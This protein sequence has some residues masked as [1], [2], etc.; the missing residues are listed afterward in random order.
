MRSKIYTARWALTGAVMLLPGC[1]EITQLGTAAQPSPIF[2][3]AAASSDVSMDAAEPTGSPYGAYLAGLYAG[4]QQDISSAADFMLQALASDP[5]NQQLLDR[6]FVFN[7]ADGRR[8]K[9]VE[10]ARRIGPT[11]PTQGLAGLVLAVDA[12]ARGDLDEADDFLTQLPEKG[13]NTVTAPLLRSWVQVAKGDLEAAIE[14]AAP[15]RNRNGFGVFYSLHLALI[16]DVGGQMDAAKIAYE[17]A[18]KA[19]DRPTLRLAWVVGNFFERIGETDR[20]AE[21]YRGMLERSSNSTLFKAPLARIQAGGKPEPSVATPIEGMAEALFNLASLLSQERAEE[22]ALVHAHLA[23]WLKPEFE[24]TLILVG[25]VLQG[26]GRGAEA[27]AIYRQIP[28]RSP[29]SWMAGLRVAEELESLERVDEAVA[30]FEALA[31]ARPARFEPLYRLGNLLR[32]RERFA[33]AVSAYDRAAER[34]GKADRRHWS[35]YYFRG[36]ALERLSQW[37]R[38]EKDFLFALDLEPDQPFVL[39]YL[40]YSWIEKKLNLDKAKAMLARAV[41]LRPDDGFIVDSLGW[42]HYRLGEYQEGVRF[43]ERAVELRPQDPVINDHLGD[44]YWRVGRHQEAR[45][46]WRRSLSLEPE[47]DTVP[48]IE[49]KIRNGLKDSGKDI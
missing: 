39:N 29:L 20:A 48:T 17:E 11:N 5:E 27:I 7:A 35:L 13:L 10:L 43:L 32:S 2:R 14:R 19:T 37:P 16:N 47:A 15:L 6:T 21:I 44:V 30:E 8:A 26:Q 33:E 28:T 9:A 12:A 24:V 45:F 46:Q 41:E 4:R 31:V 49:G 18:L 23:L 38:A 34:L 22:I 36:I 25:E 42:V 40:A 3:A 1:A